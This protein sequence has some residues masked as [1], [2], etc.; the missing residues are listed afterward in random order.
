MSAPGLHLLRGGYGQTNEYITDE[1]R[2]VAGDHQPD[3]GKARRRTSVNRD[4]LKDR[5]A[6]IWYQTV[7]SMRNK[8][9]HHHRNADPRCKGNW[10]ALYR[11][12]KAAR[13]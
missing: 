1:P 5:G 2:R 9:R 4:E 3:A 11:M 7:R 6:E 10:D 8:P 13:R 12:V